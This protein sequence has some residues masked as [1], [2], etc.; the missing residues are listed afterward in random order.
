V[1]PFDWAE[2]E[3]LKEAVGLLDPDDPTIRP[4]AGGTALMLMMKAGV[5]TPSRLVSLAKIEPRYFEI[6]ID[7]EG[8]IRIGAMASLSQL[9]QSTEAI[10]RFPVM[11]RA[12]RTLS[13]VRVRNVARIGGALAHGDPHMDLPPLLAALGARV[14]VTGQSG[15]REIAIEDLYAGYYETT[16]EKNELIAEAIVPAL[17]GAKAAYMKVTSRSAD[18]WPALNIGVRL[19]TD[20]PGRIGEARIVISAAT[21]KVTRL[22][23]TERLLTDAVVND[24]LLKRAGDAAIG[25][26]TFLSDAHGS[27]AYKKELLRVYL[28]RVIREALS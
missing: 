4:I 24:A 22:K 5:F 8:T 1:I 16:L 7:T 3:T 27:A 14:S 26:V 11:K 19:Q 25:E 13:N 18:D 17:N 21:E 12:L 9:E 20:G 28:S 23:D 15:T 10:A 2:P 6:R